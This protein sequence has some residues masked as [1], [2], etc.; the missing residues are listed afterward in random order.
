MRVT[1]RPANKTGAAQLTLIV[2]DD[3]PGLTPERPE[4]YDAVIKRG[5]RLDETVPGSGLGLSIVAELT[6]NYRGAFHLERSSLGGLKV[7]LTLPAAS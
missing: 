2:E 6:E 7:A 1:A 3:G 5:T 4:T